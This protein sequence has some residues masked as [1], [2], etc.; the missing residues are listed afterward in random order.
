M[1]AVIRKRQMARAGVASRGGA[2]KA[3]ETALCF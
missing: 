2:I 1:G 3:S